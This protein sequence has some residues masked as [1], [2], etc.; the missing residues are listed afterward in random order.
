[1][2]T[3]HFDRQLN[4]GESASASFSVNGSD[5]SPDIAHSLSVEAVCENDDRT[6][7]NIRTLKIGTYTTSIER[8][9]LIEEFTTEQCP[10]C[11]ESHQHP[12]T[13]H[14]CRVW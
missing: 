13:V 11:P 6:D 14:Q 12:A 2:T 5:L 7:N 9:V 4:Y 10:N 1:M 3:S 8:R